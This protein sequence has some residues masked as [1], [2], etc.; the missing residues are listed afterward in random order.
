MPGTL[1]A[2]SHAAT[3]TEERSRREPAAAVLFEN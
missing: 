1:G 3:P 2:I